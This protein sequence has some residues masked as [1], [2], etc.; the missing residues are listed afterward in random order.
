MSKKDVIYIDSEDDITSVIDKMSNSSGSILALVLPKKYSVLK[1]S[2]NMKLLKKTADKSKKK[3]VLITK[4]DALLPLAGSAGVFVAPTLKSRPAVPTFDD[5]SEAEDVVD[6]ADP[7]LD[8][9]ATL[10]ELSDTSEKKGKKLST[11][12]SDRSAKI[13]SIKEA[14]KIKVPNFDRFRLRIVLAVLAVI[15]LGVGWYFAFFVVPKATVVIQ[16]QTSRVATTVE[17]TVDPTAEADDLDTNTVVG[18][19]QEI[20]KTV[21]ERFE[22]TGEKDVGTKASGTITVQNCDSDSTVSLG[23]GTVFTDTTTGF[24]FVSDAAVDVPGGSFSG[25][26]CSTPGE[27]DVAVTAVESGD[28]RNLSPRGYT[29]DG[30]SSFITGF[31]SSM[32]GGTSEIVTVVSKD[33]I[34][35][36]RRLLLDKTD[37]TIRAELA[38]LFDEGTVII[39]ES[40]DTTNTQPES[41]VPQNQEATEASVSAQFTYS[42]IGVSQESMSSI[43][44]ARQLEIVDAAT[45]SILDNGVSRVELELA[46][47]H[48]EDSGVWSLTATTDGFVGPEINVDELASEIAGKR[49]SEAVDLMSSRPGVNSVDLQLTP[50]WVFS[51]P[52]PDKTT[53]TIEI[54]D[55]NLQ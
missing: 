7:E 27:A 37:D 52:D 38:A 44:E 40:F 22:A 17:F 47:G 36:A 42:I 53:I 51:V 9:A 35:K 48:D 2:V 43:L 18:Q 31:G 45:Q 24:D 30:Q 16:A 55:D 23:S 3:I 10:E 49:F 32:S 20:S 50:F 28:T 34:I 29:V 39:D 14:S 6:E 13:K 26:G 19:V 1:S 25:G 46:E 11:A 41:S 21:T 12:S 15:G 5:P 54:S 4:E 33:D 8:E